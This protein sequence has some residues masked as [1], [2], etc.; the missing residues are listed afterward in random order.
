L[1][2]SIP[3]PAGADITQY[4]HIQCVRPADALIMRAQRV[5]VNEQTPVS[6][7]MVVEGKSGQWRDLGWTV[8]GTHETYSTSELIEFAENAG[9]GEWQQ[10]AVDVREGTSIWEGQER[11]VLIPQ[12]QIPDSTEYPKESGWVDVVY[13]HNKG[14]SD[15]TIAKLVQEDASFRRVNGDVAEYEIS[16]VY[17][18]SKVQT[19]MNKL[20]NGVTTAISYENILND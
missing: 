20:G 5:T 9:F 16:K 1:Y 10:S 6:W 19:F 15:S 18:H 13:L 14:L 2:Q 11:T 17:G 8:K 3:I 12:Y 7:T 4:N